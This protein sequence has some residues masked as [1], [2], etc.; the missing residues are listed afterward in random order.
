M[1]CIQGLVIVHDPKL[2][3][4][5]FTTA[6]WIFTARPG[7]LGL[8][9]GWANPTGVILFLILL[10]MLICSH[11]FVRRGGCFEVISKIALKRK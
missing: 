5:N 6:E 3:A 2:N 9:G 7:I 11:P 4:K 8:V 1:L 10:V